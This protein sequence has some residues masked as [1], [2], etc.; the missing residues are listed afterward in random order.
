MNPR[1]KL[2]QLV[3]CCLLFCLLTV[4]SCTK[5]TSL[6]GTDVEQEEASKVSSESDGEAEGIF[7]SFFDDAM[8]AN[9]DVG[10]AGSGVFFGKTDT[11]S[12]VPRCFTVSILHPNGTPFPTRIIVDFGTT[13]C[14]GPDGH[15]RRGRVITDYTNRLTIPGAV[16]TTEFD[17]YY[18]D[19]LKVEGKHI[20][21]NTG[22]TA[23][24]VRKYKVEVIDGKLSA[25]NGDY[26][27]W[28]SI[29]TITQFEG[30]LTHDI[31]LDD[32]FKIEGASQGRVRR[33]NL[34]VGWESAT[35]EPLVRR[36]TC[37][38]IVKGRVRT[39]RLNSPANSPWVAF[40]DFGNGLCNDQ[41]T[42]TINGRTTQIT[43]R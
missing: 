26:T 11:L 20:I 42:L 13:G 4:N 24:P 2:T 15:V 12:P 33:G 25:A 35:I 23:P 22:S 10:V 41:A 28:N 31:S 37:R 9:N 7:G 18:V 21:T 27:E 8:G 36:V 34:L 40:L 17:G 38:W 6:S 30:L 19:G 43:L 1:F 16:A 14:P 29:K 32:A 5:E 39:A 3:T